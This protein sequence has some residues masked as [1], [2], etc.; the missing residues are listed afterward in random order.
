MLNK[1]DVLEKVEYCLNKT[2]L[3]NYKEYSQTS[4]VNSP[5]D[6]S[7]QTIGISSNSGFLPGGRKHRRTL[8]KIFL[9]IVQRRKPLVPR[10]YHNLAE[11][12]Q[13]I[14]SS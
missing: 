11:L 1:C 7:W 3:E 8:K 12:L 9:M 14:L 13:N 2:E 5:L 10:N 6:L 4:S